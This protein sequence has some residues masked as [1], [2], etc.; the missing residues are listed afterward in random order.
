MSFDYEGRREE[1]AAY[2]EFLGDLRKK[3]RRGVIIPILQKLQEIFGYIP[4][5]LVVET[6]I[7][8]SI[9][10]SELYAVAT[11]YS[12]FSMEPKGKYSINICL[13]TACYV[14]GAAEVLAEVEKL[15]GIKNGET[16]E[17]GMFSID[18]TRCVGACG[19]APVLEVNGKV[20][21]KV[22]PEEVAEIIAKCEEIRE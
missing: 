20:Y 9:P 6:S 8:L 12:Q 14:K 1:V 22:K 2:Y 21:G 5:E 16:T 10:V 7:V 18:T 4:Y 15:L 11:F 13:G 17:D 19:L 3:D